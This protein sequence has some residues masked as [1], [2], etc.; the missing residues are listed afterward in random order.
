MMDRRHDWLGAGNVPS[1]R[2]RLSLAN[3]SMALELSSAASRP[4]FWNSPDGEL[5]ARQRH[6]TR[7][8]LEISVNAA[9]L[10]SSPPRALS[11][12]LRAPTF[13]PRRH[14]TSPARAS[15]KPRRPSAACSSRP[16]A[17][18]VTPSSRSPARP[19][20]RSH[21][22]ARSPRVAPASVA[23]AIRSHRSSPSR[24]RTNAKFLVVVNAGSNDVS[25]FAVDGGSLTLIDR[26]SSG[27]VR[28]VSVVDLERCRL[29][30]QHRQQHDRRARARSGWLV[31][32]AARQDEGARRRRERRRG[33]ARES[34]R[35]NLV[36]VS[37]RVSNRLET[38]AVA[39]D[40]SLG[41]PVVTAAAGN[42]A[43]RLRL[44][45]ARPGHRVGGGQCVRVVVRP[46]PRWLAVGRDLRRR[47][48]RCSARRAG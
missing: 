24:C 6:P 15:R 11:P 36:V 28:P 38:F 32:R 34:D 22:P 33:S 21:P 12:S 27:G 10:R 41:D 17:S 47:R 19:M 46:E 44:R 45:D 30:A 26:A 2:S 9:P 5:V 48:R 7:T 18:M 4:F 20:A 39:K 25:S 29:R 8:Q 3:D 37:E 16:T 40:G 23:S 13:N 14:A 31:D 43:V 35:A 1:P 42:Y